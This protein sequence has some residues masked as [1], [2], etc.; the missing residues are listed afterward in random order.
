MFI[1]VLV[2]PNLVARDTRF[3][4]LSEEC[5]QYKY[6]LHCTLFMSV[7]YAGV[8]ANVKVQKC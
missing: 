6:V 5:K 8:R 1:P 3:D 7:H 2:L 4:I